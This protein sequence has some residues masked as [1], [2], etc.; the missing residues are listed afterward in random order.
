MKKEQTADELLDIKIKPLKRTLKNKI[1]IYSLTFKPTLRKFIEKLKA[2]D[3]EIV[4][5]IP[6][7]CD[8]ESYLTGLL[9]DFLI[10]EAY[11]EQDAHDYSRKIISTLVDKKGID[12]GLGLDIDS[13]V[14]EKIEENRFARIKTFKEKSKFSTFLYIVVRNLAIEYL[15]VRERIKT[16]SKNFEK[17]IVENL[18]GET[19][20][21]E[22]IDNYREKEAL[23]EKIA[24]ILPRKIQSL[25]VKENMAFRLYY[26]KH[27]TNISQIARDIGTTRHKADQIIKSAWNKILIE[28]K[29]EIGGVFS[30]PGKISSNRDGVSGR[31]QRPHEELT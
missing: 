23:K 11:F 27:I 9:K 24:A 29:N 18:Y 1:E 20:G 12:Q 25:E 17:E 5:K 30:K 15:R 16:V 28:I 22:E 19:V 3:Y 4:R 7:H 10:E 8:A 31:G 14:K 21:P 13:F 26:C 6:D 2:N